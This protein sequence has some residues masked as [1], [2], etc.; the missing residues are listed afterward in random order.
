M[1]ERIREVRILE[2]PDDVN[3]ALADE[4]T[5]RLGRASGRFAIALAGGRTPQAAYARLAE[6]DL[7]W[8]LIHF[9]W[10]DE[11]AVPPDAPESNFRTAWESWLSKVRTDPANVHRI[12]GEL[13]PEQAAR[14]CEA[15][16]LRW[17][18]GPVVF[19][20]LLLGMGADGHT[21]SLFPDSP[22]L[23]ETVR[24]ACAVRG[25]SPPDRITLTPRVLCAARETIVAV[26]GEDKAPAL[27]E[28]LEGPEDPMRY[29]AQ[30]LRRSSGPVLWLVDR[31]AARRWR[32]GA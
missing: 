14:E 13:A 24:P 5:R 22:A 32:P 9:F 20:L 1:E 18:A 29:P 8:D 28:V 7:P 10:G 19:D 12:R 27:R 26:T 30:C 6:A 4:I 17:F 31:A 16:L 11:R 15:E 2:T 3:R 23:R 25:P 21:A